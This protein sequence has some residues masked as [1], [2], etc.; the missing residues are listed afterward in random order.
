MWILK[1]TSSLLRVWNQLHHLLSN[2]R[3]INAIIKTQSIQI[4]SASDRQYKTTEAVTEQQTWLKQRKLFS[5]LMLRGNVACEY[6][7]L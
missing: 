2:C 4:T 3:M 1:T 5:H 6:F 7:M